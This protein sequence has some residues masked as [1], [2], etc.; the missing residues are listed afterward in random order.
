M[1]FVWNL[2]GLPGVGASV[3]CAAAALLVLFASPSR[4]QNR[5]LA[6]GLGIESAGWLGA[7]GLLYMTDDAGLAYAL[8][9][10]GMQ[11]NLV[12]GALLLAFAGT[13]P[14]PLARPFRGKPAW[15]GLALAAAAI[16]VLYHGW[17]ALFLPG[18]VRADYAHWDGDVG[19]LFHAYFIVVGLIFVYLLA[20][21]ISA[22]RRAPEGPS[23]RRAGYFAVAFVARDSVLLA[24]I[25]ADVAGI[26]PNASV[27]IM[28][29]AAFL[30]VPLLVYG[31]LKA[32]LFDID[33]KIKWGIQRGTVVAIF[34]IVF[35]IVAETAQNWLSDSVGYV[36]GGLAAAA[37]LV[38]IRP[39]ERL[40]SRVSDAALPQVRPTDDYL[41]FRKVEVYRAALES[42]A[43]DGVVTE[44]E[45]AILASLRESL[46]IDARVADDLQ[47]KLLGPL[48]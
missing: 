38:V 12:L 20:C 8:Q 48:A 21:T 15:I 39:L 31:I 46:G 6:L 45:R 14:T 24:L 5:I 26:L 44:K 33:L 10:L 37:L 9:S 1:A 43:Q 4:A 11:A 36:A 41:A 2:V 47:R 40:A 32:Q 30:F 28:P 22:Y 29:L 3:L 23:K 19:P 34:L 7:N 35:V 13:L 25:V 27:W 16:L 17:R 18:V 42:A